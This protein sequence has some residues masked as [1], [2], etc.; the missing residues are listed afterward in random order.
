[1]LDILHG[2]SEEDGGGGIR[3][4][5]LGLRALEGRKEGGMK[6]SWF[7]ESQARSNITSH[8]EVRILIKYRQREISALHRAGVNWRTLLIHNSNITYLCMGRTGK[9]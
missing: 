3:S 7:R 6:E 2:V 8:T 1:M 4:T 9:C 5:H